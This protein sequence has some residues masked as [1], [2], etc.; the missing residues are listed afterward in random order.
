MSSPCELPYHKGFR[1]SV[2]LRSSEHKGCRVYLYADTA[3][4]TIVIWL[5]MARHVIG[6]PCHRVHSCLPVPM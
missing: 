3:R 4:A 5:D 1:E 6:A 2:S